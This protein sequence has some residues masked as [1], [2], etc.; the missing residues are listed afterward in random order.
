MAKAEPQAHTE[1]PALDDR[2]R[3]VLEFERGWWQHAG[4]K[5][6]AVRAEF[7]LSATRYYQILNRLIDDPAALAFDPML[8]KRLRRLR[9]TRLAARAARLLPRGE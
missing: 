8:I 5:E 1:A 9:D 2:D 7:G 4:L 3:R 6:Q